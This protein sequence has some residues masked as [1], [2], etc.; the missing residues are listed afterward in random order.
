MQL[1]A[2][3]GI[4]LIR[5]V[6]FHGL[7]IGKPPQG[8]FHL[9]TQKLLEQKGHQ[10]FIESHDIIP[11]HKGHLYIQ[12]SELRLPVCPQVFITETAD[13]LEIAVKPSHHQELFEKLRGLWQGIEFPWLYPAGHQ[14]IPGS[15]R[16][17]LGQHWCFNLPKTPSIEEIPHQL[18]R[19]VAKG[20]CFLHINSAQVQVSIP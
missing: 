6:P 7:L 4:R 8:Q 18:G 19:P 12:L 20:Q 9:L 2:E 16:S 10:C 11:V 17:T 1:Q 5:S 15:L 13:N 3:P 14:K